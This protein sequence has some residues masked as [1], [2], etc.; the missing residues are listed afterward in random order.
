MNV[1]NL[2]FFSADYVQIGID[3]KRCAQSFS[4]FVRQAWSQVE[5]ATELKWGWALEA[6]CEHLEAVTY[7]EILRLLMN[8]P[9]G[10]MKSL[11]CGV[12]WPAWEWGP[13]NLPH[14]RFLGTSHK[15][16][17]AVRDNMKCRRLIDSAWYQARWPIQMTTDQNAK[18][19]F[20]NTATG[21]R[22]AMA[23]TSMTGS[24]GDRVLLDDPH[25]VDQANSEPELLNVRTTFKESL[26]SRVNNDKS[27]IVVIMQRLH[28]EDV[29]GIIMSEEGFED[30]VK[31]ILP[32]Y[33]ESDRRCTTRI[34]FTDPRKEEGEL[35]FPER[36]TA[37]QVEQLSKILGS[38]GTAGQLQ[39]RPTAREGGMFKRKWF[40]GHIIDELPD[41]VVAA[42]RHWDL[43]ATKSTTAARTAGVLM[44]LTATGRVIV[45]HVRK[46]QEEGDAVRKTILR[47]S[48]VDGPDVKI[49]LP[50]DPGQAGK[51]QKSDFA[52]LLHGRHFNIE[53]E[54][55]DKE[56]RAEPFASQCEAGN[57][58]ILRGDWNNDYLDE[59]CV[60]PGGKFKDQVDA[61]SG[62]YGQLV[63]RAPTKTTTVRRRV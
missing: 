32:M 30:Y 48:D 15:Q 11:L 28:E 35:L 7:G 9:P 26:P 53:L 55:G 49:S 27:A 22:E 24:R 5:P 44:L 1:Q 58:D 10:T 20:E 43:A 40:D 50:Q 51:V 62:A 2:I 59:L 29:S 34:G 3:Q 52:K 46:E 21:F 57:V 4:Y 18:T 33:F 16:D 14:L 60:F 47:T 42:C 54:S 19:K 37:K 39:Q 63:M 38:Y 13:V 12:M 23:F 31:L 56:T 41:D 8:V 61:S 36:H 17:L 45:A 6:M 25:S